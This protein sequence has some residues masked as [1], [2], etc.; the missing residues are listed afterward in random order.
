LPDTAAPLA[1]GVFVG[2]LLG[3]RLAPHIQTK[4]VVFLLV[5]IMLYLAGHLIVHLLTGRTA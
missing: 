3:A 4:Y 2:S 5:G 1:A